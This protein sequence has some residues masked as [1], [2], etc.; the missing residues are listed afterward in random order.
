MDTYTVVYRLNM[1]HPSA[2]TVI[3]TN[4]AAPAISIKTTNAAQRSRYI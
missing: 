1:R 3:Q 2:M 4:T